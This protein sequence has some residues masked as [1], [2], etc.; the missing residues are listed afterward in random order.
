VEAGRESCR[1][2]V[3]HINGLQNNA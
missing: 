1:D 3:A 2:V